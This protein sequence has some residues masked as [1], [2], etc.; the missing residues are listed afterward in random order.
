MTEE[1]F[2]RYNKRLYAVTE[3]VQSRSYQVKIE[4]IVCIAIAVADK[5]G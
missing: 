3:R 1:E 2:Q 5:Y 4:N